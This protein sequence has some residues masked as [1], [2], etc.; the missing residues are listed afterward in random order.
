MNFRHYWLQFKGR[1]LSYPIAYFSKYCLRIILKTCRV[2]I[3]GLEEFV[4]T[5]KKEKCILMLWH[6]RLAV[7]AEVLNSHAPQFTYAAFISQSRDGEVL[8]ILA[9]SYKAGR[10]IRIAHNGKR[11]ALNT[12]IESLNTK[13]EIILYTPDGPKGPAFKVKPGI[14][15]AA[16]ETQAN[17]IPFSWSSTQFWSLKTWDKLML[18]KPFSTIKV[19]FGKP[20]QVDPTASPEALKEELESS[21]QF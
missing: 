15:V 14:I 17:I 13:R 4:S 10:T 8:A 16:K 18:P 19:S 1:C 2:E 5:A 3:E 7:V 11:E 12:L 20:M 6:N 9:R 21:L